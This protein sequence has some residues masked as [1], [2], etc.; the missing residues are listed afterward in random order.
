MVKLKNYNGVVK[1]FVLLLTFTAVISCAEKKYVI[2][3]IEGKEIGITVAN[4]EVV[5]SSASEQAQ[6]IENFIKPYRDKIDADLSAVLG[7]ATE[8]IDKSG[9]WQNN[10]QWHNINAW[11]KTAERVKKALSKGNEI[12][13]EGRIV[14]Q[15]YE[16]KTGEKRYSTI[17]EVSDFLLLSQ[18]TEKEVVQTNKINK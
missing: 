17:V 12:I 7:N 16:T 14:N 3:K 10:T 6:Q 4:S 2:T 15:T 13:L 11:A 8:S 9:E 18:K 1:H 5:G